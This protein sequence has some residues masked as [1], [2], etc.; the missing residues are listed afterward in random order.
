M[1]FKIIFI[2]SLVLTVVAVVINIAAFLLEKWY[3]K[4]MQKMANK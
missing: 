4:K 2:I 3:K 1:N